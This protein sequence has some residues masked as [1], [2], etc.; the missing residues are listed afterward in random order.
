MISIWRRRMNN[1]LK[2]AVFEIQKRSLNTY[3]GLIWSLINPIAQIGLLYFVLKYIFKSNI[4]HIELWL[5]SG[6]VVWITFQNSVVKMSN[7]LV[8]RRALIQNNNITFDLLVLVDLSAEVLVLLPFFILGL[9]AASYDGVGLA[10]AWYIPIFLTFLMIFLYG[11]GLI[12]ATITPLLRDV[13]YLVGIG[14]Q[15]LFWITPIAYAKSSVSA[16][17]NKLINYNPFSYFIVISQKI[18]MGGDIT[19]MDWIP[20]VVIS[21]IFISLGKYTSKRLAAKVMIFL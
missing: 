19:F 8:S 10:N 4:E 21:L 6:M 14:M 2:L 9:L 1:V 5:I 15:I 11:A 12:L 7:T 16:G 17:V 20:V 18:F 3:A 13:P